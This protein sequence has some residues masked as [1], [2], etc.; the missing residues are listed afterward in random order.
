MRTLVLYDSAYGNTEQIARSIGSAISGD[1]RVL[2][3]GELDPST[4]ES[5]GFLIVGSPT[6]GGKPTKAMQDFLDNV[7]ESA[8]KETSVAAFDTRLSTKWVA[9]FGYAAG[10]IAKGLEAKGAT[11]TVSP[12]AFFVKGKEGPLKEG[13]LERAAA[14]AK[15]AVRS[16]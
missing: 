14:W 16:L 1:V 8:L 2:R 12:E 9:I 6:Q 5:V 10:R 11:L 4:L 7:P 15:E 3:V 13:E